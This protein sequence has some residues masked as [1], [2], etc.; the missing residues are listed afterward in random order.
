[1]GL[2][3]TPATFVTNETVTATKLN[4]EIRDA[5]TGIQAA[6][7]SYTPTW[8]STGTA[9]SLGNG[10]ISGRY[11]QI[12]KTVFV[13]IALQTGSTSTYGTGAYSFSLP[14]TANLS[15][16]D[17]AGSC[18]IMD[19]SGS[20]RYGFTAILSST[21]AVSAA[22]GTGVRPTATTPLTF[23]TGDRITFQLAYEVA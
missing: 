21:T 19:N 20:N 13:R 12:G 2:N 10:A 16:W 18:A 22:D 3:T 1:V 17:A 5:F 7:T 4:T 15:T 23:A 11:L 6:W 9:P 8:T 14:L